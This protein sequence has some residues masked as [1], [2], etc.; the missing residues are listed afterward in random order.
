[1]LGAVVQREEATPRFA[2]LSRFEKCSCLEFLRTSFNIELFKIFPMV[3]TNAATTTITIVNTTEAAPTTWDAA[4][5]TTI[6]QFTVQ[7]RGRV[8]CCCC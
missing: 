3:T 8:S 2:D 7:H 6:A 5:S 4:R 1:M